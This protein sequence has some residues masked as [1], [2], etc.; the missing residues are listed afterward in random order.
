MKFTN[1]PLK[2]K[3][4]SSKYSSAMKRSIGCRSCHQKKRKGEDGHLK[5]RTNKIDSTDD[6]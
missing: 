5:E 2:K 3:S 4:T 1:Q 6:Q